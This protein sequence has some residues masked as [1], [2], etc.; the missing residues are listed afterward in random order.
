[1]HFIKHMDEKYSLRVKIE[2]VY[3]QLALNIFKHCFFHLI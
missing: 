1:M 3:L 2:F